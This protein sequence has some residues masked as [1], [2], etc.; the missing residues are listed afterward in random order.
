MTK[1]EARR[2]IRKRIEWLEK[3]LLPIKLVGGNVRFYEAEI[4]AFEM[5]LDALTDSK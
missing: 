2:M 5:A 4:T 1:G 3:K